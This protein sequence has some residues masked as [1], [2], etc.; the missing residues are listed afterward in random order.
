MELAPLRWTTERICSQAVTADLRAS[1]RASCTRWFFI[2]LTANADPKTVT[3]PHKISADVRISAVWIGIGTRS[4]MRSS[5]VPFL[6]CRWLNEFDFLL[7][8][9]G[10]TVLD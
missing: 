7:S 2:L 8:S 4:E 10:H 5:P 9:L 6:S 1:S 3:A